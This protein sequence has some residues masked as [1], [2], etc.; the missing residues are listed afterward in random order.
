MIHEKGYWL[1]KNSHEHKYDLPLNQELNKILKECFVSLSKVRGKLK[2][3]LNS[4]K[5]NSDGFLK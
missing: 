1:E 3:P 2:Y 5:L 4:K